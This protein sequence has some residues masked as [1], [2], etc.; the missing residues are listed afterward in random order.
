MNIY[1]KFYFLE[2][3]KIPIKI[4]IYKMWLL[5]SSLIKSHYLHRD[6][7]LYASFSESNKIWYRYN[8][9]HRSIYYPVIKIK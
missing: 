9:I 4:F 1:N 2:Y 7:D 8:D 6:F 3:T 5:N